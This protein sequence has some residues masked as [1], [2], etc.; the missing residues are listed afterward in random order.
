MNKQNTYQ[1]DNYLLYSPP[2]G[3]GSFSKVFYGIDTTT[4]I[5]VAIK[6]VNKLR[7]NDNLLSRVDFEISLLEKCNHENILKIY[8]V[9]KDDTHIYIIL[10]YCEQSLKNIAKGKIP[11]NDV[12]HY[13]RQIRNGLQYL[14]SKNILHRDIKPQNIL[15]KNGVLKI[16][17][18]GL[19]KIFNN[20]N[21]L[22]MTLC[23]SPY[24]I[25]PEILRFKKASIKSDLWSV[26]I[27]LY[28]LLFGKLPYQNCH[29]ILE[30]TKSMDKSLNI[31]PEGISI[32]CLDL[33]S[34]LLK[35]DVNLRISWDDFFNHEW[36]DDL[37]QS[38][39]Y[40]SNDTSIIF[41]VKKKMNPTIEPPP[42]TSN[43][44][45]I[46]DYCDKMSASVAINIPLKKVDK[47]SSVNNKTST[48]IASSA[49][50]PI[51]IFYEY[52]SEKLKF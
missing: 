40:N 45:I 20:E 1:L 2:I 49:P 38:I 34:Q 11:E 28:Q 21:D 18:F 6:S 41:N 33:L 9:L 26:G 7:L 29:N 30:L 37:S 13:S 31:P 44:D 4:N 15:I 50:S 16:S 8:K 51:F 39:I 3:K 35:K 43:V 17:D 42:S 5:P 47:Q 19:S 36:F 12:L 52:L 27:V 23:G 22:T 10:E 32:E 14:Y 48:K 24:Y 46:D 25:A